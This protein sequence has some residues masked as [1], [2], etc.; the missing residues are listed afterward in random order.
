MII[1]MLN[2]INENQ[3]GVQT[4]FLTSNEHSA[5]EVYKMA[6]VLSENTN[7]HIA[8]H[9]YGRKMN[10]SRCHILIGTVFEL[11][12]EIEDN[13]TSI[14]YLQ[15]IY[16]D[17]AHKVLSYKKFWSFLQTIS[18]PLTLVA[19][20]SA[21]KAELRQ[22]MMNV[23]N[24]RFKNVYVSKKFL[25][26]KNINFINIICNNVGEKISVLKMIQM[27]INDLQLVVSFNVSIFLS[28]LNF[29]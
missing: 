4:I 13:Q 19:S 8:V 3:M 17:K 6:Y 16:V 28:I 20:C 18:R 26:G 11:I 25:I 23:S 5:K 2:D 9:S 29:Q 24:Q 15:K 22:K 12:R 10:T 7:I 14:D 1:A 27:T 21:M